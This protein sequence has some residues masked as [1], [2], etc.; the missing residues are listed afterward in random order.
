[1]HLILTGE[2]LSSSEALSAGLVA[3]VFPPEQVL[4]AAVDAGSF[5]RLS[6]TTEVLMSTL[7]VFVVAQRMA[8]YST[9]IVAM[10]KEAVLQA[11]QLSLAD[12]IRFERRLY[13]STFAT[14]DFAE[15]TRAFM[16]KRAPVWKN[17]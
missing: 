9:P 17:A 16:E 10:A 8:S 13:H 6:S 15:G 12:G 7:R 1:M 2:T 5:Y 11:D 14:A 4:D 3:K